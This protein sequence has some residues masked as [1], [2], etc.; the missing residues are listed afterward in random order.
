[1]T[2]HYCK[3]QFIAD[4]L[5]QHRTLKKYHNFFRE[6]PEGGLSF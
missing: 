4:T 1:M 3:A 5:K 6:N 2:K